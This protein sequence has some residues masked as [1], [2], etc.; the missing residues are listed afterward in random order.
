[1]LN[2]TIKFRFWNPPAKAFVEQYKYS[3]LVDE[4]FEQDDMLIPCQFT[5]LRDFKG[6]DLY[7]GD[8]VKFHKD[9]IGYVNFEFGSFLLRIKNSS[10]TMGFVFLHDAGPV[11]II[12]NVFTDT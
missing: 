5:G 3:G 11:E 9:K 8:V 2:R 1:M 4:L 6:N 12:G 7:E 10:T